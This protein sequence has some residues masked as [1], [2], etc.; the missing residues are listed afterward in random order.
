MKMYNK[1]FVSFESYLQYHEKFIRSI[2]LHLLFFVQALYTAD[3]F[4]QYVGVYYR[5][6]T[7]RPVTYPAG[8]CYLQSSGRG[9]FNVYSMDRHHCRFVFFLCR[10]IC[11]IPYCRKF[12]SS[13]FGCNLK[14]ISGEKPGTKN[15]RNTTKLG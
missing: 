1:R 13:F 14:N 4:K 12:Q 10:Q 9:Y 6:I 8:K 2:K 15:G 7:M 5:Q 11:R 3:K